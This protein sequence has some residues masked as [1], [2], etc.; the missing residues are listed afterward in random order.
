[1]IIPLANAIFDNNLLIDDYL[2]KNLNIKSLT[3]ASQKLI[4]QL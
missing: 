1:M 2:N 3:L 4:T